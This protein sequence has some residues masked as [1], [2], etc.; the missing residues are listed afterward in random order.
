MPFVLAVAVMLG[1]ALILIQPPI[2]LFLGFLGYAV[3]GPVWTL[4]SL[5]DRRASRR[6][7]RTGGGV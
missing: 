1:I 4:V 7:G 2:V 3:S 6:R 5:R